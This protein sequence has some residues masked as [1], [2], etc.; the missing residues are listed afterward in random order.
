MGAEKAYK[1]VTGGL[2]NGAVYLLHAVSKDNA[3]ILGAF[4]DAAKS[5]GYAFALL[6]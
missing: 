6:S 1:R 4:I 5:G 3:E 2:H